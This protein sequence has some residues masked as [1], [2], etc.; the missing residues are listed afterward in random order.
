MPQKHR[1]V[2]DYLKAVLLE[3]GAASPQKDEV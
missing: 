3:P 1:A 2:A